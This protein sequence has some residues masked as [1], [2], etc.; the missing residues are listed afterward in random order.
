[1]IKSPPSKQRSNKPPTRS[2]T[3][4]ESFANKFSTSKYANSPGKRFVNNYD[5]LREELA[6]L[7]NISIN[8]LSSA[9]NS[10][11]SGRN[12]VAIQHLPSLLKQA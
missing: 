5:L 12:T 9:D 2:S 3:S 4:H 6:P 11:L 10:E 1:M 7:T 8:L